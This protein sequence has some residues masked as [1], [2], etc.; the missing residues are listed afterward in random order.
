MKKARLQNRHNNVA[1]M[2]SLVCTFAGFIAVGLAAFLLFLIQPLWGRQMV[3]AFGGIATVWNTLLFTFQALLFVGYSLVFLCQFTKHSKLIF[4][5]LLIGT[6]VQLVMPIPVAF[7]SEPIGLLPLV[8]QLYHILLPV[9]LLTIATPFIQQQ[10]ANSTAKNRYELYS[11]SNAGSFAALVITPLF[12]LPAF[13]QAQLLTMWKLGVFAFLGL[14][15]YV[16]FVT[17]RQ[18]VKPYEGMQHKDGWGWLVWPFLTTSLLHAYTQYLSNEI[19]NLPLIWVVPLGLF[20]L[21]YVVAFSG[22]LRPRMLQV[23]AITVGL[24]ISAAALLHGAKGWSVFG[25]HLIAFFAACCYGHG[26][27]YQQRPE[28]KHTALFYVYIAFAGM[29]AGLLNAQILPVILNDVYEYP[30]FYILLLIGAVWPMLQN[31]RM[32]KTLG[33]GFVLVVCGL[34]VQAFNIPNT[35]AQWR[36]YYGVLKVM[37]EGPLHVY[38]NNGTAHEFQDMRR[39]VPRTAMYLQYMIGAPRY[40][41]GSVAVIGMGPGNTACYTVPTQTVDFYE[42][43]PQVAELASDNNLF[44]FQ[45]VCAREGQVVYGDGRIA[46]PAKESPKYDVIV[47]TAHSGLTLPT[48]LVTKEAFQHYAKSLNHDGVILTIVPSLYFDHHN[49]LVSTANAAG[50][51]VSFAPNAALNK[52]NDYPYAWYAFYTSDTTG[53]MLQNAPENIWE[54]ASIEEGKCPVLTDQHYSFLQ[55]AGL[56]GPDCP[57]K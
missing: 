14:V 5:V 4:G 48:H 42:I 40:W 26:R 1:S 25:V 23:L 54:I 3:M 16:Y 57:N 21:S 29:I 39:M 55:M 12:L 45:R 30:V 34:W 50:F 24:A 2:P 15:T 11:F 36:S 17:P 10:L 38:Y 51:K 49:A 18:S 35:L 43:N 27:L 52:H 37:Q 44:T 7:P 53:K 22:I 20:L 6:A 47:N 33:A 8:G 46:F 28:Q 19:A 13:E 31:G 41:D 56:W 32:A 9:L